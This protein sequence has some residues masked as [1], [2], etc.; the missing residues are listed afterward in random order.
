[1]SDELSDFDR[2]NLEFLRQRM[3]EA[4]AEAR[5]AF[6]VLGE[7]RG[8]PALTTDKITVERYEQFSRASS[9][10]SGIGGIPP[11]LTAIRLHTRRCGAR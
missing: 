9:R 6:H 4:E 8:L 2:A 1:M 3:T 7:T 5:K 10:S 11:W